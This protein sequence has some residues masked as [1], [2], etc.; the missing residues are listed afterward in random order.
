M[1]KLYCQGSAELE[2]HQTLPSVS[3]AGCHFSP[4]SQADAVSGSFFLLSEVSMALS[5]SVSSHGSSLVISLRDDSREDPPQNLDPHSPESEPDQH[6][7]NTSQGV[8]TVK[9]LGTV[10]VK[11]F[12]AQISAHT[13]GKR[14]TRGVPRYE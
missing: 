6:Q 10:H 9:A 11:G 8:L 12:R 5:A 1:G 7:R 14:L 3:G 13:V 2:N 4:E